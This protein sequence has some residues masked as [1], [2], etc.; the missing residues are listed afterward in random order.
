MNLVPVSPV[1]V[2]D[3]P[4][5]AAG[6]VLLESQEP[7]LDAELKRTAKGVIDQILQLR[8]SL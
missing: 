6:R 4:R 2:S 8:D 7:P 1:I 3:D 5:V